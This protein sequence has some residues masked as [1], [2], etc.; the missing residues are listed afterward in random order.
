MVLIVLDLRG[1]AGDAA[2]DLPDDAFAGDATELYVVI[3]HQD[4]TVAG[5]AMVAASAPTSIA[6]MG[7][8]ASCES[9]RAGAC[10]IPLGMGESRHTLSI[11][12]KRELTHGQLHLRAEPRSLYALRVVPA[13]R[14]FD[15]AAAA[16]RAHLR[17]ALL[18]L[19]TSYASESREH[20]AGNDAAVFLQGLWHS[21]GGSGSPPSCWLDTA[22]Q[23]IGPEAALNRYPVA[24]LAQPANNAALARVLCSAL[25]RMAAVGLL[26]NAELD[27]NGEADDGDV[28]VLGQS[29]SDRGHRTRWPTGG[30]ASSCFAA[31][32]AAARGRLQLDAAL[33]CGALC[34]GGIALGEM[35]SLRIVLVTPEIGRWCSVGGLG[36]MVDHFSHALAEQGMEVTVIAPAYESFAHRW[37]GVTPAAD[38]EVPFG[39][40][41]VRVRVRSVADRGV[42]VHLL[43]C[44]ACFGAPYPAGDAARRLA[45]AVVL[46][47]GALL[48][49]SA[50][51]AAADSWRGPDVI[52]AND[53]VAALTAPYARYPAWAGG[54]AAAV[55]ILA[56]RCLFV[57]LIHNLE[58]GYDGRLT[59]DSGGVSAAATA[60]TVHRAL[61]LRT[62]AQQL[63]ALHQLP[64]QLM[65]DGQTASQGEN[66]SLTRAALL[67]SSAWGTVSASY[68]DDL[69]ASSAYAPLLRQFGTGIACASG[70]PLERRRMELAVHGGHESAK[71]SLQ[72]ACFGEE[73]VRPDIP[74]LVFLGRV[75]YQK[76]IHLLLDCVPALLHATGGRAQLLV[77]GRA[78]RQD[79]YAMRCAAQMRQLA[80]A[81]PL[82]FWAAPHIYFDDGPLAS[83]AADFGVM[84]S[85]FEPSGLVR[86]EFFAAGTP[87]LCSSAGGLYERVR[88]Y[89]RTT[90]RGA[91]IRFEGHTH[92]A[93]LAALT[94][95]VALFEEDSGE[96]YRA[97]RRNAHD[98]ACD[99]SETAWHWRCELHRLRACQVGM[100]GPGP[101]TAPGAPAHDASDD[102]H[103]RQHPAVH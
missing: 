93:L 58:A 66:V 57:H 1:D 84:P 89:D 73:G 52:I 55:N 4:A 32:A 75:S 98:A 96:H 24:Q 56:E 44:P 91:G 12:S 11:F 27:G 70:I 62:R 33:P 40:D 41:L 53:W 13:R 101:S 3:P 10:A 82:H 76:G 30:K 48:L 29:G 9:S 99:V 22:W 21:H 25:H 81:Y 79:A 8:A 31:T 46:A 87:L 71:A 7:D 42:V 90:Q 68:R 54:A 18:R 6:T 86:E 2:V 94:T 28:A 59:G 15:D 72:R 14:F 45:P 92:N 63:S 80:A 61:D 38:L 37:R 16:Q 88:E 17:S 35:R 36:T 43:E 77:C 39:L 103:G 100:P 60:T 50:A 64:P 97:L 67:C 95:A 78:D 102:A 65:R 47:R 20:A 74:L 34:G 49:L 23:A 19:G 85:L 51:S 26:G 5:A 83:L 69:L